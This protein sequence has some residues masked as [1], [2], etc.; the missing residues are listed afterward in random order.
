MHVSSSDLSRKRKKL[1]RESEELVFGMQ[2]E[3]Y[4]YQ[5][6]YGSGPFLK[7]D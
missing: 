1:L 6:C 7:G 4:I 3:G 5:I 2:I